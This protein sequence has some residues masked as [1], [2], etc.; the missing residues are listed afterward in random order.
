M[1]LL[2]WI[3]QTLTRAGN[4]FF[5][6]LSSLG[7]DVVAGWA[8]KIGVS[9]TVAYIVCVILAA[10]VGVTA[11][12]LI[13]LYIPLGLGIAGFFLGRHLF[14][15]IGLLD[16]A[17]DW[18]SYI[19]GVA[20]AVAVIFLSFRRVTYAWFA[21]I[22]LAGYC[23]FRFCVIDDFWSAVL[24]AVL[25]AFVTMY[26]IR[27]F[28]ILVSGA[29]C[30]ALLAGFLFLLLPEVELLGIQLFDLQAGN[31]V[32]WTVWGICTLVFVLLQFVITRKKAKRE[33]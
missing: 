11:Y 7:T 9:S 15:H 26:A 4:G 3:Y 30:G 28:F 31:P 19:L 5:G 23:F 33:A 21:A 32:F 25:F 8:G 22:T 2:N 16:Q 29:A 6:A 14:F 13:K 18:C 27:V 12:K 17:P 1:T 24:L 20:V 10:V